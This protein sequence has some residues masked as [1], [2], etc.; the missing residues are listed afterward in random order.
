MFPVKI[1]NFIEIIYEVTGNITVSFL[2]VL[3]HQSSTALLG[4][5]HDETPHYPL[6]LTIHLPCR[7]MQT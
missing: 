4:R 6:N 7:D 1:W 5:G 2:E 3:A